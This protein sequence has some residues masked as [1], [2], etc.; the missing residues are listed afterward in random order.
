MKHINLYIAASML[1]ISACTKEQVSDTTDDVLSPQ[2]ALPINIVTDEAAYTRAT[3]ATIIANGEKVY[4]FADKSSDASKYFG[5]WELTSDGTG[6]LTSQE[7]KNY[8]TDGSTLDF[9]GIHGN[10]GDAIKSDVS[11]QSTPI[12]HTVKTDQTQSADYCVSDLLYAVKKGVASSTDPITISFYHMLSKVEVALIPGDGFTS[13]DLNGAKVEIL[14]TVNTVNFTPEKNIDMGG[15]TN[16]AGL[17]QVSG[18][19]AS[20]ITMPTLVKESKEVEGYGEA[21]VVSQTLENKDFI[22]I[23]LTNGKVYTVP[24]GNSLILESGKKYTYDL[25]IAS[26]GITVSSSITD[27]TSS[28]TIT[29]NATIGNVKPEDAKVGD[30]YMKDGSLVSGT[31]TLTEAQ[32]AACIGIVFQTDINRIGNGERYALAA[33]G[34]DNPNGLVMALVNARNRVGNCQWSIIDEVVFES[35][36]VFMADYYQDIEGYEKTKYIINNKAELKTD[37]ESFYWINTFGTQENENTS[38]FEA[39]YNTTGWFIPSIGQW[40]DIIENLGGYN[41]DTYENNKTL[42]YVDLSG[43]QTQVISNINSLL[44]KT[45]EGNFVKIDYNLAKP[46]S[47][48]SER[49]YNSICRISFNGNLSISGTKKTE[50]CYVRPILAF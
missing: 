22:R 7:V 31:A 43:E 42:Q 9:Y 41:L 37:Y 16:R 10:F 49:S 5:A 45:G 20:D 14:N 12:T 32:K 30:F 17:L 23:T 19:T 36:P 28:E 24:S 6:K 33:K 1:A 27:W 15:Q 38:Q 40:W 47:T 39:P 48:S 50:T 2:E 21:V 3:Q 11:F 35:Q 18:T 34:I 13:G 46:F 29:G 26:Y 4:V 8:P 44:E 25:T